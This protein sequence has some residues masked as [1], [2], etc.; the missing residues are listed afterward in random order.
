MS[1]GVVGV[2]PMSGSGPMQTTLVLFVVLVIF[3]C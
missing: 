1:V 3:D 2:E